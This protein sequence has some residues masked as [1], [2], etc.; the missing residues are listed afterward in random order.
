MTGDFAMRFVIGNSSS[1]FADDDWMGEY[2]R[3]AVVEYVVRIAE[4]TIHAD[5]TMLALFEKD[6]DIIEF[7][8]TA[9]ILFA[10]RAD[11]IVY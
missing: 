7:G 2:F 5:P 9:G 1:F 8:D 11:C 10:S 4:D 6:D 3:N